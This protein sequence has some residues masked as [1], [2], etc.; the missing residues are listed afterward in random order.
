MPVAANL[1]YGDQFAV[2]SRPQLGADRAS[3]DVFARTGA[4]AAYMTLVRAK[5]RPRTFPAHPPTQAE[6]RRWRDELR[7]GGT[8]VP[9]GLW[10]IAP[11]GSPAATSGTRAGSCT[12]AGRPYVL[13]RQAPPSA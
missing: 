11:A 9:G 5:V 12:L 7:A 3:L 13:V 10:V 2:I 6:R 4:S 8:P 1:A